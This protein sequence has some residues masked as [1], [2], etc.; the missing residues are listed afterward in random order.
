MTPFI[1]IL[2]K[3]TMPKKSSCF[4]NH[5]NNPVHPDCY[6][7]CKQCGICNR[8]RLVDG[9]QV[10]CEKKKKLSNNG[11]SYPHCGRCNFEINA[12]AA[13]A[14][15]ADHKC[16]DCEDGFR[17]DGYDHCYDCEYKIRGC[18][19]CKKLTM[20]K[21]SD[22]VQVYHDLCVGC[23]KKSHQKSEVTPPKSDTW[24]SRVAASESRAAAKP[25][26]DSVSMAVAAV[27]TSSWSQRA[28][29]AAVSASTTPLEPQIA[30]TP[31]QIAM[32]P[33][34]IAVD[35]AE[36]N[37]AAAMAPVVPT[38]PMAPVVSTVPMTRLEI[39]QA[40][41]ARAMALNQKPP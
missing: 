33:S 3:Q 14:Y 19:N 38:V 30:M 25:A 4:A 9:Q 37:F 11:D 41:F 13:A 20:P 12:A 22:G 35:I 7:L 15:A 31:S 21:N 17:C 1:R 24:A 8:K 26:E 23:F 18:N 5:C 10:V 16:P 39:A 34:Q 28:S 2:H 27:S 36:A 6:N 40:N 29:G 32:T